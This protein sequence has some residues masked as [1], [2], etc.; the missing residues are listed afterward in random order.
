MAYRNG[1]EGDLIELF[2]IIESDVFTTVSW[3]YMEE[4]LARYGRWLRGKSVLYTIP[5]IGR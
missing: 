5:R 1:Y 4:L 2:G 3:S